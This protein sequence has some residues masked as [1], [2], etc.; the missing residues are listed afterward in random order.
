MT[1]SYFS[2]GQTHAH[3][4]NNITLD[5]DIIV[6]ITAEDPREEM[7]KLFGSVWS[8]EYCITPPDMKYFPRG[9]YD[10]N[11]QNMVAA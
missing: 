5:K 10:L 4:L 9:I 3:R 2:F 8:S 11:K 7:F 6:K 1:T